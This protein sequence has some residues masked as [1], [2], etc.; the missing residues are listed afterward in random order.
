MEGSMRTGRSYIA[1][2]IAI[3]AIT[4]SGCA[5]DSAGSDTNSNENE[6]WGDETLYPEVGGKFAGLVSFTG[7]CAH[8]SGAVTV[9]S[10]AA[11]TIIIGKRAVDSALLINGVEQAN[12]TGL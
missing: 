2:A 12:C 11:Q 5:A 9:T 7:T 1:T 6:D 10:T 3:G 4:L 8:T